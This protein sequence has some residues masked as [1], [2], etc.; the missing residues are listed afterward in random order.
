MKSFMLKKQQVERKWY[1]VD[2]EGAVLG[3]LAARIAPI[4]IG[5]TKAAYTP[6][7]DN[8]D[9]VIVINA[10]KIRVT[11]KKAVQK[12]YQRYSQY[13]GGHKIIKFEDMMNKFPERVVTLAVR[14]ML[15]KNKLGENMI[16]RL[17]V[18]RGPHHKHQAQKPEKIEVT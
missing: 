17:K 16:K 2:A 6:H 3:R 11:G 14:R 10:E 8:G 4:I 18:Y 1:L 15:P 7:I 13:P 12:E 5:K 9:F